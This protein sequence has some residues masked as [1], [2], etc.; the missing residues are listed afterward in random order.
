MQEVLDAVQYWAKDNKMVLN[1]KKTKDMWINF[2][3]TTELPPLHLENTVIE[4]VSKFTLLGVWFQD[5]LK[6]NTHIE[7]VARK[8]SRRL[9]YLRECRRAHLPTDVGLTTYITKIRSLLEYSSPVWGG[10]PSF[11]ADELDSIQKR[12]LRIIGLPSNDYLPTLTERRNRADARELDAIRKDVKHP[13]HAKALEKAKY[14]YQLRN[15]CR[16]FNC[17]PLSGKEHHRNSFL[18]RLLR[19]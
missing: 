19:Q 13:L 7:E 6:W 1:A 11:L 12:S 2:R 9:H 17:V 3:A 18:P 8:A 10:L 5:D 4:R 15:K 14:S 16:P